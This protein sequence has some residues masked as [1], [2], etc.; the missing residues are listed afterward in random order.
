[1]YG[2]TDKAVFGQNPGGRETPAGSKYRM[3]IKRITIVPK[4]KAFSLLEKPFGSYPVVYYL[5]DDYAHFMDLRKKF[6]G[7]IEIRNLIGIF[8]QT[9]E[10]IQAPFIEMLGKLNSRYSSD[11]WWGGQLVSKSTSAL[12]LGL[13]IT[14]LFCAKKILEEIREN[15]IFIVESR[16]LAHCISILA[17]KRGYRVIVHWTKFMVFQE[18]VSVYTY[19]LARILFFLWQSL[20]NYRAARNLPEPFRKRRPQAKKRIILRTWV[21]KGSFDSAGA[22]QERNFG[23]LPDWLKSKGYEVFIFPMFFNMEMKGR[24]VYM[25]LKNQKKQFLIPEHYLRLQDYVDV[26]HDSYR[27][28]RLRINDARI[29]EVDVA[30]LINE[31]AKNAEFEVSLAT[32]NLC[33]PM[34]KRLSARKFEI[35][36]F[37]YPFENNASEKQFILGCQ[38]FFPDA[39]TIGFQHTAVYRDLPTFAVSPIEKDCHPLPD[40]IVCSGQQYSQFLAEQGFPPKVLESGP[41]LRYGSVYGNQVNWNSIHVWKKKIVLLPLTF[42]YHLACEL[43]VKV[44]DSISGLEAFKMLVR[45]H[46]L[47]VKRNLITFLGKSGFHEYTFA[48]EGIIQD[49]F[50]K[51]FA[52]ISTGGTIAILEAMVMGVPVIRVMPGNNFLYDPLVIPNYPLDPVCTSEEISEQLQWLSSEKMAKNRMFHDFGEQV[53]AKCYAEPNEDNLSLFL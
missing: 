33:Y 31:V 4:E 50:S 29:T 13:N 20:Q 49:W 51:T 25:R 10:E 34:L 53:L 28:L 5:S 11:W 21:T 18:T 30:P 44:R 2:P 48:D 46:P 9:F 14:Y 23:M 27:R 3:S 52:V 19:F 42:N 35:D 32:L 15:V 39:K 26:L 1:M 40:K 8:Q 7:L 16:A 47:L 22:F 43:C 17:R 38:K 6:G 24:S 36:A 37:Y 12:P 41:N 45:S